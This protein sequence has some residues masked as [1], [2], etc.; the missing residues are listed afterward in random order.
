MDWKMWQKRNNKIVSTH[1]I[2]FAA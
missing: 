2:T 1:T